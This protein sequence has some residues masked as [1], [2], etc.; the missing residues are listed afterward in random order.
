VRSNSRC[1]RRPVSSSAGFVAGGVGTVVAESTTVTLKDSATMACCDCASRV[2]PDD[3]S[4]W[5]IAWYACDRCGARWS[6]RLRNGRPALDSVIA[7]D[8]ENTVGIEPHR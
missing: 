7:A 4:T 3:A 6:A 2:E 5:T 8:T 1:G